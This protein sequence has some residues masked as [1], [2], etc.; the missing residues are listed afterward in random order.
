MTNWLKAPSMKLTLIIFKLLNLKE[1]NISDVTNDLIKKYVLKIDLK[2]D[3]KD[4]LFSLFEQAAE[5]SKTNSE[6]LTVKRA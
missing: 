4:F 5:V 6:C 3:L 1:E 2:Y